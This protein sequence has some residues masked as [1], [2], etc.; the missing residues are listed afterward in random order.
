MTY[1]PLLLHDC[2]ELHC[3]HLVSYIQ[4]VMINMNPHGHEMCLPVVIK[5]FHFSL[6]LCHRA[7]QKCVIAIPWVVD[8]SRISAFS[9]TTFNTC[10]CELT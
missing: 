9:Y 1:F 2:A 5:V 4:T 7:T 6:A 8:R 3:G 10:V